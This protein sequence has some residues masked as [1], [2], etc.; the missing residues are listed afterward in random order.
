MTLINLPEFLGYDVNCNA[1]HWSLDLKKIDETRV[2]TLVADDG[3]G[4]PGGQIGFFRS[5]SSPSRR[6]ES[7]VLPAGVAVSI[8]QD[9]REF[10]DSSQWYADRGIPYRRGYLLHGLPGCGKT[11]LLKLAAG[12]LLPKNGEV[13]WNNKP[14]DAPQSDMGFVFQRPTLLE[15]LDVLDNVLLPVA[16]HKKIAAPDFDKAKDLLQ[17]A[18]H[19]R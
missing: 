19:L 16:L 1:Y 17:T 11:S 10:I 18:R 15:W 4:H 2:C 9:C 7:V 3:Y 12:L 8:L 6:I 14:L 13:V 5:T